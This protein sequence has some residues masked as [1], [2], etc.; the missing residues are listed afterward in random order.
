[1]L[2][3]D[4]RSK[5]PIHGLA[6]RLLA[7][8]YASAV[9]YRNRNFDDGQRV[10]RINAPVISIGNLSVGG[11][12]KTPCV[13][14]LCT[15]L[16]TLGA[17][18][19]I[20]MRGYKASAE[21]Q[22]DEQ[23]E[24]ESLLQNVPVIANPNRVEG[25]KTLINKLN[26]NV[27]VMDDGFQHR[28][29]ARD[30]DI[31]LIDATRETLNDRLLPAGWLREP[32]TSL[33]RASAVILTRCDAVDENRLTTLEAQICSKASHTLPIIRSKHHWGS[34]LHVTANSSQQQI[35]APS[36]LNKEKLYITCG[37]GHPAAFHSAATSNG[38]HIVG[39]NVAPDHYAWTQADLTNINSKAHSAGATG[40]LTTYKDWVKLSQFYS[41]V[42]AHQPKLPFYI[43]V[44]ELQFTANEEQLREL[45]TSTVN[46]HAA[47]QQFEA[48]SNPVS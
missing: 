42:S 27:V 21:G 41:A 22:S 30:L 7:H 23:M 29:L 9:A 19:G 20:V 39:Q 14:T 11:T 12:G 15:M 35:L 10:T 46:S 5:P 45:I 32:A 40:I 6:G 43:P 28:K 38:I 1:M 26:R 47:S 24:Y 2:A 13:R 4:R 3:G 25:S 18:P 44:V 36:S 16:Q 17:S 33:S 37:I 31:V 8:A 48:A 34:V